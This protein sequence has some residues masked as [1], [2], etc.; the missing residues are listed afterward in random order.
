MIENSAKFT[1]IVQKK[2]HEFLYDPGEKEDPGPAK[3]LKE[4]ASKNEQGDHDEEA[5]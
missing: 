3:N 2:V 5:N 4:K 1:P